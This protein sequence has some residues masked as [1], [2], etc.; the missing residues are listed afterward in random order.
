MSQDDFY[1]G[2]APWSPADP[3]AQPGP[4]ASGTTAGQPAPGYGRQDPFGQQTPYGP[5]PGYGPPAQ[6]GPPPGYGPPPQYGYGPPPG[7]GPGW[8]RPTNGLAIAS[9][10]TLVLFPPLSLVLGLVARKQ[11]RQTGEDG[12]GLALAGV[13]VGAVSVAGLVAML[14]FAIFGLLAL[15]SYG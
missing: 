8:K 12:D 7:Y 10:V 9:V 1:R 4:G 11:I 3:A 5:P 14:L 13:I 2:D 6:Y 15:S